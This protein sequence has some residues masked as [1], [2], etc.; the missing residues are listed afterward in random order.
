M[1]NFSD[2][3]VDVG[4]V[5]HA[6]DR[7]AYAEMQRAKIQLYTKYKGMKQPG[8][9]EDAAAQRTED[10]VDDMKEMAKKYTKP[11]FVKQL[12][13]WADFYKQNKP[14]FKGFGLRSPFWEANKVF[15]LR[16][17]G[18]VLNGGVRKKKAGGKR[19]H[20]LSALLGAHM[21]RSKSRYRI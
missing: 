19:K 7:P 9:P 1:N 2:Y 17:T 5:L 16:G 20:G 18:R 14:V 21:G 12:D 3:L 13:H 8:I 6:A 15:T 4:K 11:E 10:Y